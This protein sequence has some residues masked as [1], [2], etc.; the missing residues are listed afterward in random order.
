M[1][2]A[3]F[4]LVSVHMAV[5]CA[6]LGSLSAAARRVHCSLSTASYRLASLEQSVGTQLFSRDQRGLQTTRTG[7][8]F[9]RHAKSILDHVD[10]THRLVRAAEEAN[11]RESANCCAASNGVI[12]E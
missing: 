2:L 4:D 11:Q 5:L 12:E 9:V 8:L 6:E 7:E 3:R 1:N 10:L